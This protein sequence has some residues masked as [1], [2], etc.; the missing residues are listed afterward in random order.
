MHVIRQVDY[1]Q[2]RWKNGAGVSHEIASQARP[3]EAFAWRLSIAVV[4]QSG[5]FSDYAG[6]VRHTALVAG[7]GFELRAAGQTT[8]P[9]IRPGQLHVYAGSIPYFCQLCAGTSQD[10]NLIA[11]QGIQASLSVVEVGVA[12]TPLADELSDIYVLPLDAPL[13]VD[14]AG[15]RAR[16][17][18]HDACLI[19]AGERASIAIGAAAVRGLVALAQVPPA[20]Q[21]TG[22]QR[23]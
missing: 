18:P 19:A 2:M 16:L 23:Q 1:L 21:R 15:A 13:D 3:G 10:L 4:E 12:A 9:F 6:Y 11:K 20:S 8:L 5:A 17:A 7:A 22:P 14:A